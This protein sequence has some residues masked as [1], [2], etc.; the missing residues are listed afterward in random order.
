MAFGFP[1]VVF[2]TGRV[3]FRMVGAST[4]RVDKMGNRLLIAAYRLAGNMVK[5]DFDIILAVWLESSVLTS[6]V[7]V[8]LAGVVPAIPI[9]SSSAFGDHA[10]M[11][12]HRADE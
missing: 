10:P 5:V 12:I 1:V 9:Y 2:A 6:F 3:W 4:P 7:Y 8:F 11:M